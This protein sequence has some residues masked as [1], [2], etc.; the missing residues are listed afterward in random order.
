M[1]PNKIQKNQDET[2]KW[3]RK[4]TSSNDKS[5]GGSE[6]NSEGYHGC[7]SKRKGL[8]F[9]TITELKEMFWY[10]QGHGNSY[11]TSNKRDK[12]L[13]MYQACKNLP[14]MPVSD[15]EDT[16][17][18]DVYSKSDESIEFRRCD[19]TFIFRKSHRRVRPRPWELNQTTTRPISLE[20]FH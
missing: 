2:S 17:D 14:S 8:I 6:E 16:G 11:K 9:F 5:K 13:T 15:G 10:K 19:H 3:G 20:L 7:L 4:C 1:N 18:D 12:I